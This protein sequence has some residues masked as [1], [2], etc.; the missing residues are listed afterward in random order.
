V[1]ALRTSREAERLQAAGVVVAQPRQS[2][3][4]SDTEGSEA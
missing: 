4:A 1:M 2:E 3:S